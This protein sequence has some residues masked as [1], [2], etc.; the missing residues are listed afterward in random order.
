MIP[1]HHTLLGAHSG[2]D[3]WVEHQ[4]MSLQI[5]LI[6]FYFKFKA[7]VKC[8]ERKYSYEECDETMG[9]A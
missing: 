2:A 3:K 7:A 4:V 5:R 9:K 6:S 1:T 8:S